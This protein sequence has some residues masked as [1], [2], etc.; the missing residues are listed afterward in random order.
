MKD[1]KHELACKYREDVNRVRDALVEYFDD[2]FD[3]KGDPLDPDVENDDRALAAY[4]LL[5][6]VCDLCMEA[7]NK[8]NHKEIAKLIELLDV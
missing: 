1:H 8:D 7:M 3:G 4:K 2:C 5:S 6:V